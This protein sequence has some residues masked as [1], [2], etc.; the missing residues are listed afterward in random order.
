LYDGE[1]K[2]L[3]VFNGNVI[4]DDKEYHISFNLPDGTVLDTIII[5]SRCDDYYDSLYIIDIMRYGKNDLSAIIYK[6]RYEVLNLVCTT[7]SDDFGFKMFGAR[8]IAPYVYVTMDVGAAACL[9][10][11]DPRVIGFEAISLNEHADPIKVYRGGNEDEEADDLSADCVD[12]HPPIENEAKRIMAYKPLVKSMIYKIT[13]KWRD[14]SKSHHQPSCLPYDRDDLMQ[15][16]LMQ[17]MI[18]LRK[19][20]ADNIQKAKEATFVY[21][22]LWSRFGQIAHKYS[23]QS[24]GYGVHHTRDFINDEGNLVCAY[25]IGGG[26]SDEDK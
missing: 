13:G 19:Y 22:V 25:D 7:L 5:K 20:N 16:G 11:Q 8:C 21:Q 23:K 18:A 24:R 15:F 2:F 17:V 6:S 10:C 14:A 1:R 3:P 4:I 12:N 9:K 26:Q